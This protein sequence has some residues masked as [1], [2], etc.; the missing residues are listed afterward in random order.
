MIEVNFDS[1][2]GP[3][4]NFS[5]LARG[6]IASRAHAGQPSSPK[7]AA[8]QG[9]GKMR[10]L[11]TLGL[12]Q[13]IFPPHERPHIPTLRQLGFSGSDADILKSAAKKAPLFLTLCSSSSFMWAANAATVTPSTDSE[14]GKAQITPAN[15]VTHFHRSI[16]SSDTSH[17]LKTLFSDSAFFQ[18]HDPLPAHPLLG[19][20]GAANHT[21]L[22]SL[23]LFVYGKEGGTFPVRQTL[24][25]SQAVA[26]RHGLDPKNTLFLEQNRDAIER[27]VFHNDVI[28]TGHDTLY[29]MHELAYSDSA[30]L[31]E[32]FK[33]HQIK[34]IEV[35]D[36]EISLEDAVRTY[37][38]NSQIATLPSGERLLLAP[39]ECQEDAKV[40]GYLQ[41]LDC[42]DRL[43]FV[44][45]RES[46]KNGGGPACLR[47]RFLLTEKQI[48]SIKPKVLLDETLIDTLEQW[49]QRH[50]RDRLTPQDLA[51]P[52]LLE[53]G[54][55]ALDEL[56][57]ILN[58]GSFYEFQKG[59]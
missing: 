16:E 59:P 46:M 58:L 26:R 57:Q 52:K 43:E 7:K 36:E 37:L 39:I 11:H 1:L 42:F 23:H 19:D 47:C 14:S 22:G 32:A 29:L 3:T 18:H 34:C 20:E 49:T 8:L 55:A 45:L 13:G 56:T 48:G 12:P 50:Y 35:L 25:A 33:L 5:G 2:V 4:H 24:A 53:E 54:R 9:L 27:G 21:R 6:N 44:D 38:F 31:L 51:D 30:R 28:A 41:A 10:R 17:M 40:F 15:L